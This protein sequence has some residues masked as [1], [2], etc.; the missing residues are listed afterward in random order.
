MTASHRVSWDCAYDFTTQ[1][2]AFSW[3]DVGAKEAGRGEMKKGT[4]SSSP[5]M[6]ML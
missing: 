5:Q 6:E 4:H 1:T 2:A 3:W